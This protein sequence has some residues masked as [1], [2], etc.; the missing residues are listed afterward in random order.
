MTPHGY[1]LAV[2]N[3][4]KQTTATSIF[5][6]EDYDN[7]AEYLLRP[8][9]SDLSRTRLLLPRRED[10]S[11]AT[12]I[13]LSSRDVWEQKMLTRVEDF[14]LIRT[15]EV[16]SKPQIVFLKGIISPEWI[17]EIG[18]TYMIDPAFF[19]RHLSYRSA[20]GRRN[21]YTYPSLPSSNE[22]IIRLRISTIGSRNIDAPSYVQKEV[23]HLRSVTGEGMKRYL[24]DLNHER[25]LAIGDSLVRLMSVHDEKHFH[26]EQDI[27]ICIQNTSRSWTGM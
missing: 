25:N 4:A 5:P 20:V 9:R 17:N 12:I 10:D 2:S 27:S 14:R 16:E 24:N 15:G 1:A 26:I 23:G 19:Q 22:S 3:H 13:S 8:F 11:I 6:G 7:L 21:L 18:S